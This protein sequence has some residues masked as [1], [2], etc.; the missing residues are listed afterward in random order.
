MIVVSVNSSI[1]ADTNFFISYLI[2]VLLSQPS[3]R[4][5][6][7]DGR[8]WERRPSVPSIAVIEESPE[9]ETKV[10]SPISIPKV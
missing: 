3:L 5:G 6:L 8:E 1:F 7:H 10:F 4:L 9:S 2:R